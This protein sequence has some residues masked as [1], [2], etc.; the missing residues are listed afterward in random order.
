M[1]EL[2]I[3]SKETMTSREIAEVTG[4]E[5]KNVMR[6]IDVLLEQGVDRLNFELTSYIDSCNRK[7]QMYVLTKKGCYILAS[8]Y[9]ALLREKIINRWEELEN[10]LKPQ[11]PQ[12]YLEALKELVKVEE[13][14]Q[15]LKAENIEM[16][17]KA[18]FFDDVVGSKDTVDMGTVAKI[19]NLGIGRNKLFELLREEKVLQSNNQPLQRYVDLGWFRLVESKYTKPNGDTCINVKTVVFQKGVN[20]IRKIVKKCL[21]IE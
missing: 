17:P 8:G 6:D 13:E 4:K 7:Q 11:L 15:I 21:N 19:L 18:E 9:N 20:G 3:G 10:A 5:H 16:L 1:N 2:S 14:K 12:T